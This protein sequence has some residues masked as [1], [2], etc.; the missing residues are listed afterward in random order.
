MEGRSFR[1]HKSNVKW[2][3]LQM[4]ETSKCTLLRVFE[5]TGNGMFLF[6]SFIYDIPSLHFLLNVECG[7]NFW[8]FLLNVNCGRNF[9]F[10]SLQ[11]TNTIILWNRL[12]SDF[13]E[14]PVIRKTYNSGTAFRQSANIGG[15]PL[16]YRATC[17]STSPACSTEQPAFQ[18]PLLPHA[19]CT[20]Q[21]AF[22]H[23]LL[24][25]AY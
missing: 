3:L 22:E 10:L 20:K 21:P 13:S 25:R 19:H 4:Q 8:F 15:T 9:W 12:S 17:I 5:E 18:H 2:L 7:R 14:I 6:T 16:H 23:L 1:W 24:P 11:L